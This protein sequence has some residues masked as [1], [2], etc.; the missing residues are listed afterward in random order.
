MRLTTTLGNFTV[1]P[2]NTSQKRLK[3]QLYVDSF[4]LSLVDLEQVEFDAVFSRLERSA[5]PHHKLKNNTAIKLPE[6]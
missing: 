2:V 1:S 6:Q 4:Y 3:V 5:Q